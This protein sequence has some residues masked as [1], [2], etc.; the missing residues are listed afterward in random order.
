MSGGLRCEGQSG[1][2][3]SIA[4]TRAS[5][6]KRRTFTLS[7]PRC[8]SE[9]PTQERRSRRARSGRCRRKRS[10]GPQTAGAR[11]VGAFDAR[12]SRPEISKISMACD[13]EHINRLRN[14]TA[15]YVRGS[16]F[17]RTTPMKKLLALSVF[18]LT[19]FASISGP[20]IAADR[21]IPGWFGPQDPSPPW[22][23]PG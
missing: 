22:A 8:S 3:G 11:D 13:L 15:C 23:P 10:A 1:A 21:G 17:R 4:S 14:L 5:C 19:V 2:L 20:A 6:S 9:V 18:L 12:P 16:C 7:K